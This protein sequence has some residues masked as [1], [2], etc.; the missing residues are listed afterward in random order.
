MLS[1]S[2]IIAIRDELLP[3]QGEPFDCIAFARAILAQAQTWRSMESAP[4]DGTAVALIG[5]LM[6]YPKEQLRACVSSYSADRE[7]SPAYVCGWHFIAPG[8]ANVFEPLGWLPLP[9]TQEAK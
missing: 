3:S 6:G 5:H 2:E 7:H 8:Y 4:K 1:D 9:P